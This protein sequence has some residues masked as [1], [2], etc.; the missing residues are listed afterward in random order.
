MADEFKLSEIFESL[1]GEG[2]NVGKPSLF[3]RLAM[4]NLHCTWCDTKYT[5]DFEHFDYDSEVELWPVARVADKIASST[6]RNVVI[7][8][9]EPLLQQAQLSELLLQIPEQ[10]S[11]E[12][13]TNGTIAPWPELIAR[14]DQWNVSPKLAHA[15]DPSALRLRMA[16]L[17][18]FAALEQAYLKLVLED[19]ANGEEA[20]EL[21]RSLGWSADRV[22]LM[23]QASTRD[24]LRA[25]TPAVARESL[26]R[27]YRFSSRLHLELWNGKRGT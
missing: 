1:Q 9:G 14:V 23:P 8:G 12:V 16:V 4:C 24:E 20:A 27:G 13:E 7:T 25:R 19:D 26:Q 6:T 2:L 5:W 11:I 21:V 15:G 10:I 18:G 17:R 22:L 3:V